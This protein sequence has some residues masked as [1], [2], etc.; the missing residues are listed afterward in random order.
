M[1]HR[2]KAGPFLDASRLLVTD[3]GVYDGWRSDIAAQGEGL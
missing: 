2:V 1:R 3:S